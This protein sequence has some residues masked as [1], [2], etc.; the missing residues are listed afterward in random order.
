M[1]GPRPRCSTQPIVE[2]LLDEMTKWTNCLACHFHS[3]DYPDR[4][5][6]LHIKDCMIDAAM[7]L[8]VISDIKQ[9]YLNPFE[10]QI[11]FNGKNT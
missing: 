8:Y 1:A 11:S 9:I 4:K 3:C 7:L 10:F 2:Y 5:L 6:G